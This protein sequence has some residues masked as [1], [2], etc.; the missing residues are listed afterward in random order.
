M[1]KLQ[2]LLLVAAAI[3]LTSARPAA[4]P[5]KPAPV[6]APK[7]APALTVQ[8]IDPKTDKLANDK[9]FCDENN[10]AHDPPGTETISFPDEKIG[11]NE[12]SKIALPVINIPNG[13][14]DKI[15]LQKKPVTK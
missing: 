12:P 2:F 8:E 10:H 4:P 14:T 5:A 11:I 13:K 9:C 7:P 1:A 6:P 3:C 15:A